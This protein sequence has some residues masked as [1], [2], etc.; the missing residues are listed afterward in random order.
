MEYTVRTD[1]GDLFSIDRAV[2]EP[3]PVGSRVFLAFAD[4]GV[5]VVPG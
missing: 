5:T 1:L 4:H 2:L 3:K